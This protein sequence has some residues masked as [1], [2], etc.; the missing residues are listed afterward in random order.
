MRAADDVGVDLPGLGGVEQLAGD[1]LAVDPHGELVDAGA[2]GHREDVGGFELAIGVVAEGLF[3]R[4]VATWSSMVMVTLWL[5]IA[6]GGRFSSS[7]ISS[8]LAGAEAVQART[9]ASTKRQRRMGNP[10]P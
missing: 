7:G 1:F 6:S 3:D 8:P 4:V 10:F 9:A 2:L 5:T